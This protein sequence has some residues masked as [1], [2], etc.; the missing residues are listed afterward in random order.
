MGL[1]FIPCPLLP[2]P[3]SLQ[4]LVHLCLPRLCNPPSQLLP[5]LVSKFSL[6]DFHVTNGVLA[7]ANSILKRWAPSSSCVRLDDTVLTR[8]SLETVLVLSAFL[9]PYPPRD[10]FRWGTKNDKLMSELLYC[11]GVL[12]APLLGLFTAVAARVTQISAHP[13][14]GGN[15]E[16]YRQLVPAMA[17]LR[18]ITRIF[19]SLNFQVLCRGGAQR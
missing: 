16:A 1:P 15:P 8:G 14:A 17:A 4:L 5:E 13:E 9:P 7:T 12:Q 2:P 19:Y 6:D 3:L 18:T 10:R 11:L